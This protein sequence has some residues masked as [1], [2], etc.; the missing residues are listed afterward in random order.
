MLLAYLLAFLGGLGV[1]HLVLILTALLRRHELTA[2][3]TIMGLGL[4]S[5]LR[6]ILFPL[7]VFGNGHTG[8]T[9]HESG[10]HRGCN[11]SA[12]NTTLPLIGGE[13]TSFASC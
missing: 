7:L 2:I 8:V 4:G 12:H 6:L 1:A 10:N 11:D 5:I 9:G 13:L 3:D